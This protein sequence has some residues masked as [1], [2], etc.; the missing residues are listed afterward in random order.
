[1][2]SVVD[3]CAIGLFTCGMLSVACGAKSSESPQSTNTGNPPVIDQGQIRV[4]QTPEGVQV[5]GEKG[6]VPDGSAV[7]VVNLGDQ[8]KAKTKSA[9]DGSFSVTLTGDLNDDYRVRVKADGRTESATLTGQASQCS[10]ILP[11]AA[12]DRDYLVNQ[13]ASC[14]KDADCEWLALGQ[15]CPALSCAWQP[16]VIGV[17]WTPLGAQYGYS[18]S[19]FESHVCQQLDDLACPAETCVAPNVVPL[20]CGKGTCVRQ[21]AQGSCN[22]EGFRAAHSDLDFLDCGELDSG[23]SLDGTQALPAGTFESDAC[24]EHAIGQCLAAFRR[25]VNPTLDS[26]DSVST[27]VVVPS[28]TG[29]ELLTF[30]DNYGGTDGLSYQTRSKC[31]WDE[32]TRA[33]T[34]CVEAARCNFAFAR[35]APTPNPHLPVGWTP[36]DAGAPSSDAGVSQINEAGARPM[37]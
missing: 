27:A 5:I 14:A 11:A 8:S 24:L 34:D 12:R 22:W 28:D 17:D 9:D 29:C 25:R 37:P 20:A 7:E 18:E 36:P 4:F 16:L 6:A 2:K 13:S 31:E 3:V 10:E 26:G 21:D 32:E 30:Q 23:Y 15:E 1:M 33:L 19:L 35:T